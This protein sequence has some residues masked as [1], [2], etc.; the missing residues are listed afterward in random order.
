MPDNGQDFAYTTTGTGAAAF[1]GG[2]SLDDDADATLPN[3]PVFTFTGSQLGAKTVTETLPVSGW[4]LTNLVCTGDDNSS[5]DAATGVATLDVDAGE[6]IVCTYTNTQ[7]ATVRIIKNAVPDNGQDFAYTTTGTGAAAFTGGFSLDDDADATLPNTRL[8]TFTGSQLGAKT[9]TE[10]LP[11][12]GWGLTN[13]VCTGDDNSSVDA[14]TGVATLDVD[15]GETVICTYTNTQDATVRIIKNAVPDNGQDFAYTTTGTGAAAFTGGFSLDDDADATLPNTR[16]FTFTGSQLGAKTVTETLPVSGWGLTNL[17]CTGDDNSS[18][19]AATGV[20]T[21]DVDAGET[22]ICTYTN[23]QDATLR[24][25][26]NAVPDNGQDFAYTTTGTGAA[27]FTGGFSLDDDADATLPNTRLFTFT[28]SQLGAKT[29]TETLPVSGWGLTNLVCTGDGNSSVD[30]ATG[31]ATLD[32]DAG[33]TIVCTYTNTQDATVRIIKNA[34]PDNGQ[35]FAY[36]TTGTGAAAFTGGFTLDDD[37]DATLPNT[38]LFTFTGSQLG[39]K[40][41]T[42]TLPVS[43]WALTNLVCTGDDNSSVD[44][45]TGVATLDVD[46][47]ETVSCTYTN[48]QQPTIIV[49]K[50]TT[51]VAGGPFDFTTTAETDLTRRSPL[52]RQRRVMPAPTA[53][54]SSSTTPASAVTTRSPRASSQASS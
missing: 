21:L 38:R 34:V 3:T 23:T 53:S 36:T 43:G 13:L 33:E 50:I 4:G 42:E 1:T 9:V 31:V 49:K 48:T 12:S 8:F 24:I 5:V 16:L 52:P 20:A 2:F 22:I 15:A 41:V 51:G 32:V 26:K 35:D 47:G 39:A 10:T 37:A 7:D 18:V 28:G 29:V 40:T 54:P 14:A 17:V 30:A 45:A 25:I 46:A 27:A 19:D 11:V 44:A 6:T